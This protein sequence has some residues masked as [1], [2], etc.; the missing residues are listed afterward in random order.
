MYDDRGVFQ[1]RGAVGGGVMPDDADYFPPLERITL[2]TASDHQ[3][4]LGASAYPP[5]SSAELRG[6]GRQQQ[7]Q[8]Q[9]RQPQQQQQHRA[10]RRPEQNGPA[11]RHGNSRGGRRGKV[12]ARVTGKVPGSPGSLRTPVSPERGSP[13]RQPQ[14]FHN[15]GYEEDDRGAVGRGVGVVGEMEDIIDRI[16]T[17]QSMG[18]S[19]PGTADEKSLAAGIGITHSPVA[20]DAAPLQSPL[21][22]PNMRMAVG[23]SGDVLPPPTVDAATSLSLVMANKANALDMGAFRDAVD[24]ADVKLFFRS[25]CRDILLQK[26]DDVFRFTARRFRAE[27]RAAHARRMALEKQERDAKKK[28]D[29]MVKGQ[30]LEAQAAR[31]EQLQRKE[32]D[33]RNITTNN[34]IEPSDSAVRC[35]RVFDLRAPAAPFLFSA[36]AFHLCSL[37]DSPAPLPPGSPP[38]SPRHNP[39]ATT[40]TRD[41][42]RCGNAKTLLCRARWRRRPSSTCVSSY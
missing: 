37:T 6:E 11:S 24:A 2:P 22:S 32:L 3:Q 19:L 1:D 20:S 18:W 12:R 14:P 41:T 31:I 30:A 23:S 17:A 39:P 28:H 40:C 42:Y 16:D 25:V 35:C 4:P 21:G 27:A 8:Q 10:P 9:W 34:S 29:I 13:P 36:V 38:R 26:P 15:H 5:S 7:Q 33:P